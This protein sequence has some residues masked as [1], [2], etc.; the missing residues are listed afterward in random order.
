MLNPAL[1]SF[2][3]VVTMAF[4]LAVA[5]AMARVASVLLAATVGDAGNTYVSTLIR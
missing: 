2:A 5:G 1:D 3:L 4:E